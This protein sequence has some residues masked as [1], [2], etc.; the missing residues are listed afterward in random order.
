MSNKQTKKKKSQHSIWSIVREN[1]FTYFNLVFLIISILL[2]SARAYRSLS[3]LPIIIANIGIGIFQQ[4]RAK[5]VLDQLNV[6]AQA[7]YEVERNGEIVT[8]PMDELLVGDIIHLSGGQQIPADGVVCDGIAQVNESL[9][10]GEADEIEKV[11]DA[12]LMSGSFVVSGKCTARLTAVGDD[13]YA[14]KLNTEAKEIKNKKSEMVKNIEL[15][16]KVAG[17]I[18]IPIGIALFCEA[19]FINHCTYRVAI[20][21]MVGAVLGLIP[22]GLYLLLTVALAL[23]AIN[24]AQK[25]VML[26]DMRS[27]ETLARVDVL[28]VDK[29]GTITSNEMHVTEYF[30]PNGETPS[31]DSARNLLSRYISTVEDRNI[32]MTALKDYFGLAEPL[33]DAK[34]TEF[35]SKLKYS[36]V[37]TPAVTYRFGAPD[38]L[39]AGYDMSEACK[40]SMNEKMQMGL[41]VLTLVE[42]KENDEVE[43]ILFVALE[44][45]IRSNAKQTFEFFK[46]QRVK[47]KVIS[48][49]NPVTVSE[50]AR[51]VGIPNAE[52]YV[53]ATTL[54]SE[55]DYDRAVVEYTVFGRVKPEQK[56]S[57]VLA[58]KRAGLK[59][60][61]TGDGVNDI[62]AMK[63][64]DCSI[65]MG[66]GSDAARQAAQVVLLDS[67]FS[68]ME[69]IV[70]R[71]R[72]I[73]NNITRS[74]TL[75]M[76]KNAFSA[77]L[78]IFSIVTLKTYPLVAAQIALVTLFNTGMPAFLLSLEPNTRKQRNRF[79]NKIISNAGPA[80]LTAFVSIA[81]MVSVCEY[82]KIS[83]TSIGVMSTYLLEVAAFML[84]FSIARPFNKY[85]TA[86]VLLS[87]FGFVLFAFVPIARD[88][89]MIN[90]ALSSFEIRILVL[91]G[92]MEI[93]IIKL[94]IGLFDQVRKAEVTEARRKRQLER[95]E[96]EKS[97]Q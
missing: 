11:K 19:T 89:Y 75:F 32:T 15:I 57:L 84:L 43:P 64:A 24:L 68:R 9:L 1:V 5:K 81:T 44:N 45:G 13:C 8:L 96:K 71:G 25:K 66:T 48:G 4:V 38:I 6:L 58:M 27:I 53:D 7:N 74:A 65:A 12:I 97:Q 56:K 20:E 69:N 29:T 83:S 47:V 10:T 49:D 62:L 46:N 87:F 3:F 92:C 28:C 95:E 76:F 91:F 34:I 59:V 73:I 82:A 55:E 26:H 23:G 63:E 2:V 35:S 41:R 70:A 39:L 37:E 17:I 40:T 33:P 54:E 16:I 21:S 31:D 60:A 51:T 18:I 78:A 22:E 94:M 61:M 42:V 36:E 14:E 90:H 52:K 88:F 86:V 50:I 85:R 80:A 79:F 67:D 30:A 93:F 72:Q 77:L